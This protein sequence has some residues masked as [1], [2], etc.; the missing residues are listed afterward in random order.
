MSLGRELWRRFSTWAHT[1]RRP[2][3]PTTATAD[4]WPPRANSPTNGP[5]G[6][7]VLRVTPT[8]FINHWKNSPLKE[9]QGAQINFFQLCELLERPKPTGT[10]LMD[11]YG[12]GIN[13]DK[14]GGGGGYADAWK[15][16]CFAWEYKSPAR[17]TGEVLKQLRLYASDLE[18][19]PLLIVSDMRRIELHK[20]DSMVQEKH[21]LQLERAGRRWHQITQP[22]VR[23]YRHVKRWGGGPRF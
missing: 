6:Y 12:F 3:C 20:L 2:D 14:T 19:P 21:V 1:L 5:I 4:E 22:Y 8:D 16:N 13:V 7:G 23:N 11:G 18:N 9:R 10:S 17:I 15:R